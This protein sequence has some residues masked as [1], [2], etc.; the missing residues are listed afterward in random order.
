MC[1]RYFLTTGGEGIRQ[2]FGCVNSMAWQPRFNIA[3]GQTVPM[4]ISQATSRQRSLQLARWGLI[5][6]WAENEKMG[7]RLINARAETLMERP[8]FKA[9]LRQRRCLIPASGFYE[10]RRTGRGGQPYAIVRQDGGLMAFAGLWE[11]W[12]QPGAKIPLISCAIITTEANRAVLPI[13]RR[14]PAILEES[15]WKYWLDPETETPQTV[16]GPCRED[17]LRLYPVSRYVN[18]PRH[19]DP[20]CVSPLN[21]TDSLFD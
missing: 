2:L 9:A 11:S 1:G 16:L 12:V 8:A 15:Q 19:D 6:F 17:L 10:W 14:M 3:P 4:V 13:H 18:D 21:R 7:Q 5:P 20:Q